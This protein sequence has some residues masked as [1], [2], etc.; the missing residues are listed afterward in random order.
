MRAIAIAQLGSA[1]IDQYE[2]VDLILIATV[3]RL[4]SKYFQSYN[5]EL[6]GMCASVTT[7]AGAEEALSAVYQYRQSILYRRP[8]V[9]QSIP[10][11]TI[12]NVLNGAL[13]PEQRSAAIISLIDELY[14]S[15]MQD[16]EYLLI[17]S[18]ICLQALIELKS[19]GVEYL[20]LLDNT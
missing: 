12:R 18:D 15:D 5:K 1:D 4:L 19:P 10:A 7:R 11:S 2:F 14:E 13:S 20:F 8:D 3:K 17:A 9:R 6:A 16:M